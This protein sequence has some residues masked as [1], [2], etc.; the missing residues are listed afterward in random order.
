MITLVSS[1]C[2]S[3]D[4]AALHQWSASS[5]SLWWISIAIYALAHWSA[6]A[7]DWDDYN[8]SIALYHHWEDFPGDWVIQ[9]RYLF[10][11]FCHVSTL[12]IV[13]PLGFI[14]HIQKSSDR[15][16]FGGSWCR[17]YCYPPCLR[18]WSADAFWNG[19]N[20]GYI[21]HLNAMSI[22]SGCEVSLLSVL[23]DSFSSFF[24]VRPFKNKLEPLEI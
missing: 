11:C 2:P 15:S 20:T 13:R 21:I 18:T 24:I 12:F 7:R 4:S 5:L 9:V 19:G 3:F 22:V 1:L 16:A 14:P 23:L 6:R 17:K 10:L 8:I